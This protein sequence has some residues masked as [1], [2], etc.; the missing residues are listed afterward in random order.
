[1]GSNRVHIDLDPATVDAAP[2]TSALLPLARAGPGQ[3]NPLLRRRRV[4]AGMPGKSCVMRTDPAETGRQ[5]GADTAGDAERRG[6]QQSWW[7][8]WCAWLPFLVKPLRRGILI[9]I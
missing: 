1:M 3:D 8:R 4:Q 7:G 5:P 2:A 6:E 9:F